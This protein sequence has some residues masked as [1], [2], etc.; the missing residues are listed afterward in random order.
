MNIENITSDKLTITIKEPF[1]ASTRK[2]IINIVNNQ[3]YKNCKI[4]ELSFQLVN[5][6]KSEECRELIILLKYFK[7]HNKILILSN[8]NKTLKDIMSFTNL[9]KLFTIV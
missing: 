6:I 2:E 5:Y 4:I 7:E 3:E 9:D 8:F 1:I